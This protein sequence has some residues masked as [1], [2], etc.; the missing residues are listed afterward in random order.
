MGDGAGDFT[1]DDHQSLGRQEFVFDFLNL[2]LIGA[3][4][5]L[6]VISKHALGKPATS[7]I[8]VLAAGFLIQ[9]AY[10]NWLRRRS[11]TSSRGNRQF[12]TFWSLGFTTA[13]AFVLTLMTIK[14]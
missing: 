4:L 12:L 14:G 13:L 7:V 11:A 10:L 1:A 8:V 2:L 9:G 6:Q 5:A 3:L